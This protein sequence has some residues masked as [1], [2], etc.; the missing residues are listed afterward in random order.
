M[1]DIRIKKLNTESELPRYL[2]IISHGDLQLPVLYKMFIY[3]F[4]KKKLVI[5]I[6][7]VSNVAR[8]QKIVLQMVS[9]F[10]SSNR[11]HLKQNTNSME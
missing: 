3:L 11:V 10:G 8:L 6:K 7:F 1:I 4:K 5:K 2:N 9:N